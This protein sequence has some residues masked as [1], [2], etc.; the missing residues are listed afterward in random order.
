MTLEFILK[1]HFSRLV[2]IGSL[3]FLA[4]A[5]GMASADTQFVDP[6]NTCGGNANCHVDIQSAVI[7]VSLP[8]DIRIYPGTYNELIDLDLMNGGTPGAISF[9]A[10]DGAGN[11][12]VGTVTKGW[13]RSSQCGQSYYRR[14]LRGRLDSAGAG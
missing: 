5:S 14:L 7:A 13:D 3:P 8:A 9:Q 2:G 12:A 1:R 11:P 10:L 4:A 6:A